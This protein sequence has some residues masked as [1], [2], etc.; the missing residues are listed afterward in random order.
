MQDNF[1]IH[2]KTTTTTTTVK[3]DQLR[4]KKTRKK[5]FS[6]VKKQLIYFQV[7]SIE[8]SVNV[9]RYTKLLW[10][11]MVWF[12]PSWNWMTMNMKKWYYRCTTRT[13][14]PW[15]EEGWVVSALVCWKDSPKQ[16]NMTKVWCK[17]ETCN[18]RRSDWILIQLQEFIKI[19]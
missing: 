4:L 10:I 15:I 2:Q 12:V 16:K 3:Y 11:N 19:S 7:H 14:H 1:I 6:P 13:F 5:C 18:Q 8:T 9:L 17:S